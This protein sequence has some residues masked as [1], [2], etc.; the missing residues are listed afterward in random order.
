MRRWWSWKG[1]PRVQHTESLVA[2]TAPGDTCSCWQHSPFKSCDNFLAKLMISCSHVLSTDELN[3][4]AILGPFDCNGFYKWI[5]LKR[6][7]WL[8]AISLGGITVYPICT[9]C[10]TTISPIFTLSEQFF[11]SSFC[12]S[13]AFNHSFLWFVLLR[14]IS[15]VGNWKVNW[16]LNTPKVT[17]S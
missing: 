15:R 16:E 2:R 7:T 6:Y 1:N 13:L 9:S 10:W 14:S 17:F 12:L 4:C 3:N 8:V 11:L 5:P